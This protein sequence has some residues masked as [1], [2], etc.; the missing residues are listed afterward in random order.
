ML[1]LVVLQCLSTLARLDP[2]LVITQAGV[3]LRRD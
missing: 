1:T 2:K 3:V